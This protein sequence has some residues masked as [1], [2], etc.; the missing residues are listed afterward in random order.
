MASFFV[1]LPA[2]GILLT[3]TL[4]LSSLMSISMAAGPLK[5]NEYELSISFIPEQGQLTGTSKITL[6]PNRKITLWL[7]GLNITGSLLKDEN[8][9]EH[10]LLP[11]QEVLIIPS[12]NTSRTLYLSYTK[13]IKNGSDNLISPKG[14]SL[15]GNWYPL[16][17]QPM[18][19]HVTATLPEGFTAIMESDSFPLKQRGNT[20]SATFSWPVT[21]IHFNAGPYIIEKQQ[22]REGLFVYSMFF[23]EDK[24]LSGDYLQA[25]AG[26]L[27][28]YE[29]EIGPFPYNHYVIVA[30]RLPTGYSMPTFTLLGQIVLRL[31]FIKD[32]SLGH[33]IV[34]SWFGN[35]VEVDY[36]QGNWCEGL[37]SFLADHAYREEKGEGV[38]DRRESI[39]RYL[40][41]VHKESAIPLADFTSAS[42]NQ[43]MAEAK[44][45][46]GYIKGALFF[47]E[48][49]EKIGN[50]PFYDGIRHFYTENSGKHA[51]WSDLQKSFEK[52]SHSDLTN[53][54]SER[55]TRSDIPDLSV[56]DIRID[57][58]DN[59]PA[60]SFSLLQNSVEPYT[61]VVP[62]RIKM[63][64]ST[65][66]VNRE[67][68]ERETRISIPVSQLPL[69][70]IVDPEH[71][72]LRQLSE[73]EVP[74]IWSKFMGARKQLVI[75][76][77]DTDMNVYQPFLDALG[78]KELTI[79]T[80]EKVSNKDLA[81]NDLLFLGADQ[82]AARS[83]FGL[84]D[85][86]EEGFTLD[87]RSNPLNRD[88]VAVIVSSSGKDQTKAVAG[89]ISHYGKYSYLEFKNGRN[90]TK[91][92]LPAVSG[93]HFTLEE[94][95]QGAA[96]SS[97]S[98]F[99]EIIEQIA[100]ARVVYVGE[101]HTSFSDHM[102]QLRIIEALH[103]I[104]PH[105]AIGME[106][107]PTIS[108]PA[109]DKYTL[110]AEEIDERTFL[111]ESDYYNVWGYDYRYFREILR[112]A[113]ENKLPVIG[114]NI[115][116]RIVSEVF[117]SGNTDS[118]DKE[119]KKKLPQD[120]NLDMQGYSERLS[121]IHNIHVQGSHGS[122]A[123]S[124]F[125]Q[126][127]GIWDETMAKNISDFLKKQPEYRMVVLAGSQH[128][129]KDSGI[130]PR[131][132]RRVQVEQASILNIYNDNSPINLDQ[133]ADY[134]FLAAPAELSP[135]AKIGVVLSTETEDGLSFQKITELSPHGKAAAA[136]LLADDIV[137]EI[138]GFPI[139]DMADLRI[140]MLDA[141]AGETV[142]IKVI[143]KKSSADQELLIEVELT[144]PPSSQA[145][146]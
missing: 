11:L 14:I 59:K 96:A 9:A 52:T 25:A 63:M 135:S 6:P 35:A 41:Y 132:A 21:N 24:D 131:V 65:L 31:P 104:N 120:R 8:G 123:E 42:H 56:D 74:A 89:R 10:E 126:A 53:F 130:P 102:L 142:D 113:R 118:L 20:V 75:L 105:L 1:H 18:Q 68:T 134:F 124:G 7:D 101:T 19:F 110:G 15:S 146:P 30:N 29:K 32:T 85:H 109:L 2:T 13:T 128:T 46:V 70:F 144:T 48:L 92:I 37:T 77:P 119:T 82:P 98:P 58:I 23:K 66:D 17:D 108:Q 27:N 91:S 72:F 94:L 88:H 141:R 71:A 51:R 138:N 50:Q 139:S 86:P 140:A 100:D 28:R 39:T 61:L 93:L 64:S 116:R 62:I 115:D 12:A 34:H 83:I 73:K 117:R 129:R 5:S 38:E 106:M 44:R 121:F 90:V 111:K 33:E 57:Y 122:G 4:F 84:P 47:H 99:E 60:L 95:P 67:I 55:L 145:H 103:K 76:A 54:F 45:S 69:E 79:T 114:L 80:A 16:P 133:V 43:P 107:F 36:S 112:F 127:Q 49:R 3:L 22:V 97:L 81:Q 137:K 87:V 40:S 136:G 26:Y 125:I 143:R 78:E